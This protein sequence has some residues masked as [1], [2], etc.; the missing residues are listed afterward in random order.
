MMI[1]LRFAPFHGSTESIPSAGSGQALS[2][3]EKSHHEEGINSK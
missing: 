2:A 3:V 1:F